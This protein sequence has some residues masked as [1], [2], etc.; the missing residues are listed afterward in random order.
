MYGASSDPQVRAQ[1]QP[2]KVPVAVLIETKLRSN[3]MKIETNTTIKLQL[4]FFV[5]STIDHS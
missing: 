2:E 3:C 1:K 4:K 5:H